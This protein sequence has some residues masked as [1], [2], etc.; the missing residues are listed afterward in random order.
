MSMFVMTRILDSYALTPKWPKSFAYEDADSRV[1]CLRVSA[2][3]EGFEYRECRRMVGGF[4][5]S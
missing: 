3:V 5:R 4:W 1:G 2:P